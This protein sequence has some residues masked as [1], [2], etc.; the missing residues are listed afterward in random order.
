MNDVRCEWKTSAISASDWTDRG[1]V[2]YWT[3]TD[4]SGTYHRR[5]Q[6]CVRRI[7]GV[8][9]DRCARD[10]R[11]AWSTP[12][13]RA[14]RHAAV[15]LV[16][17]LGG[18]R[19][20]S[21]RRPRLRH[22]RG[23]H[24]PQTACHR[25]RR[26][27]PAR[28]PPTRAPGYRREA[29][30]RGD[31]TDGA[32]ARHGRDFLAGGVVDTAS[33]RVVDDQTRP[34]AGPAHFVFFFLSDC[35][36][37]PSRG[38][39]TMFILQTSTRLPH[40]PCHVPVCFRDEPARDLQYLRASNGTRR[41]RRRASDRCAGTL[42][43]GPAIYGNRMSAHGPCRLTRSHCGAC[44]CDMRRPL[45]SLPRQQEIYFSIQQWN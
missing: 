18:L 41:V 3:R 11:R 8:V 16:L 24:R 27:D 30:I 44:G 21:G 35:K 4:G 2:S 15:V 43:L 38:G 31:L 14:V 23:Y 33:G 10:Y 17:R 7:A 19:P 29:L 45:P 37:S 32:P 5:R 42:A 20:A 6:P 34:T 9:R 25:A 40:Q 1:R 12:D 36:S 22:L 13:A 39:S 26:V 28:R